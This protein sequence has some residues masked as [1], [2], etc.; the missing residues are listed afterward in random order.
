[1]ILTGE[2]YNIWKKA[3]PS[4]T[5][6]TTNSVQTG[7][8]SNPGLCLE[9]QATN[10]LSHG[11]ACY[12]G[13]HTAAT[14]VCLLITW[15]CIYFKRHPDTLE[16]P[17]C[18]EQHTIPQVLLYITHAHLTKHCSIKILC[19]EVI[20]ICTLHV[21]MQLRKDDCPHAW[22]SRSASYSNTDVLSFWIPTGEKFHHPCR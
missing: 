14:S 17:T 1:M 2:N 11:T 21:A 18:A 15:M 12:H 19:L 9:R 20:P 7:L 16:R 5:L 4:A 22:L 6:S 8:G 10:C 13:N 3:S